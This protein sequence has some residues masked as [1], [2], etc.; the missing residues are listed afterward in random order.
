MKTRVLT[1]GVIL[2]EDFLIPNNITEAQL[3]RA[4]G[5]HP[6][7]IN[8]ICNGKREI[9]TDTA[10]R[11]ARFFKNSEAFWLNLQTNYNIKEHSKSKRYY[12]F[13]LPLQK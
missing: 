10:F 3:S 6:N 5:V 7:R 13:I 9:S 1:P 4:L 12:E 2:K 8:Q 11:L